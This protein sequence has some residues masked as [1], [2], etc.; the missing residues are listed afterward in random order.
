MAVIMGS[1][2]L[3]IIVHELVHGFTW[4]V[5]LKKGFKSIQFGVIWKMLTPYC[6]SKEPLKV[7]QYM[8]G[9]IMP[10][11]VMGILPALTSWVTG[12]IF[13]LIYGLVFILV[14]GGDFTIIWMLRK[15]NRKDWVMDHPE[16][17]GCYIYYKD[18][19]K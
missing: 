15:E 7:W 4:S 14:A 5:F 9:A 16:K 11:F 13:F 12:N 18:S 8:L 17:F 6:H 3:G 1:I 19:A 2:L 10:G